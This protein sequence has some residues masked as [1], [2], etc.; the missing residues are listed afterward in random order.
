MNETRDDNVM[1]ALLALIRAEASRNFVTLLL[2]GALGAFVVLQGAVKLHS[3]WGKSSGA[4]PV[5]AKSTTT[6]KGLAEQ[7]PNKNRPWGKWKPVN[8]QYP[9]VEVCGQKLAEIKPIPYR[10]FRWGAYHVTMG[11]RNMPWSD[12]IELDRDHGTYNVIK[13]RRVLTRGRAAVRVL[14]DQ[15]NPGV[16]KGG[17]E[18]AIE[19]VHE[20][21]EYLSRR[22]PSDFEAVRHSARVMDAQNLTVSYCDWGWD[23]LPPIKTIRMNSLNVSY[24]LP[25]SIDDGNQ[26]PERAMEIAGLLIQDDLAL[27]VEG[28]DG[29]YYF[30]AG[31]ICLPGFWRM[32]D[33]IGMPLDDIHITGHVPQ[34][35]CSRFSTSWAF[36]FLLSGLAVL[37]LRLLQPV[38]FLFNFIMPPI[39]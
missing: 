37:R 30:Q 22:Y 28:L 2:L 21:A 35:E 16:V 8:F 18:A 29:K 26:A 36:F 33:K 15:A 13:T 23:D 38:S 5:D 34:C 39:S 9:P 4:A 14:D 11:L 20:L 10:P 19:L 1:G 32:T 12:W 7:D 24:D 27:M 6:G 31:S 17:G 25:L 3:Y